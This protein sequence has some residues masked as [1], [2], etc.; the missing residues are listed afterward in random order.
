MS[1]TMANRGRYRVAVGVAAVVLTGSCGAATTVRVASRGSDCAPRAGQTDDGSG[2]TAPLPPGGRGRDAIN[3]FIGSPTPEVLGGNDAVAVL[4]VV[5]RGA[6]I[7]AADDQRGGARQSMPRRPPEEGAQWFTVVRPMRLEVVRELKG[8]LPK[9]LDLDVPGGTSGEFSESSNVF[10]RQGA[11]GDR[12]LAFFATRDAR[13]P[14]VP[15][16]MA[17]WRADEEGW[18]T[19]PFGDG[20]RVD[21]ETW[22]PEIREP[23]KGPPPPPGQSYTPPQPVPPVPAPPPSPRDFGR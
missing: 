14:I 7:A 6:P 22:N 23:R 5:S 18:L 16:A 3:D 12:L 8:S 21:L 15:F 11:P 17:M 2:D 13:G 10:P 19:L 20:E 9:C 4:R 1:V